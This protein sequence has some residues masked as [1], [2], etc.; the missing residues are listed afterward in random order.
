MSL[1]KHLEIS[2]RVFRILLP[3]LAIPL[4]VVWPAIPQQA[5]PGVY[6][7]VTI[8]LSP[9]NGA[10]GINAAGE[11]IGN[12]AAP[13][14]HGRGLLVAQRDRHYNQLPRRN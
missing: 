10:T 7:V 2:P 5:P 4:V 14:D 11:I 12:Y 6:T 8:P 1:G 9:G 3:V 13:D